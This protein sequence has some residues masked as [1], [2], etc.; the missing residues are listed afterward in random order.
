MVVENYLKK[1]KTCTRMN[2]FSARSCCC[3]RKKTAH[4]LIGFERRNEKEYLRT[5]FFSCTKHVE[6]Y[7]HTD[8]R[9]P[10]RTRPHAH[11]KK[12]EISPR[13]KQRM[14]KNRGMINDALSVS[15]AVFVYSF[16]RSLSL[17][18]SITSVCVHWLYL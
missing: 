14:E 10:A 17:S 5:M 13:K 9:Q 11:L 18:P 16:L 2:G 12:L 7:T 4:N 8:N 3:I 6:H 15:L 1:I